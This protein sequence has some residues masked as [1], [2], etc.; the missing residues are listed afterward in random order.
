MDQGIIYEEGTPAQIFDNP[1]KH[2]TKVFINRI[3]NID[4]SIDGQ[5]DYFTMYAQIDAFCRRYSFSLQK[6][7]AVTHIIEEFLEMIQNRLGIQLSLF[8]SEKDGSAAISFVLPDSTPVPDVESDDISASM[9]RL[10]AGKIS[11]E[12]TAQGQGKIIFVVY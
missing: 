12:K 9:L 10:Y 2:N 1:Q 8:Y 11:T 3:R 4:F 7:D 5:F 6:K